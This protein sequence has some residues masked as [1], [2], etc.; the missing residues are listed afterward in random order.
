MSTFGKETGVG[1]V[2]RYAMFLHRQA[3]VKYAG[4][5]VGGL[6]VMETIWGWT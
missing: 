3:P 1:R 6:L 2:M 5:M 4:A